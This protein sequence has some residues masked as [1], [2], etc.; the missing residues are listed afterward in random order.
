MHVGKWEDTV[1]LWMMNDLPLSVANIPINCEQSVAPSSVHREQLVKQQE[2]SVV[3]PS[4]SSF[5]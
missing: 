4:C 2:P 5:E 1:T 3:L